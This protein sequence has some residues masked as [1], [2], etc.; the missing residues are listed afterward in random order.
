MPIAEIKIT[1]CQIETKFICSCCSCPT[2][3][4]VQW[5]ITG[6]AIAPSF[7]TW[8]E[9]K[10]LRSGWKGEIRAMLIRY[11][12]TYIRLLSQVIRRWL[13][14]LV[15]QTSV[16]VWAELMLH[17]VRIYTI[18]NKKSCIIDWNE[19]RLGSLS[20]ITTHI[21]WKTRYKIKPLNHAINGRRGM[22]KRITISVCL[23]QITESWVHISF[24]S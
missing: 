2:M 4:S 6:S 12:S 14:F 8:T 22:Q 19:I 13:R 1:N 23:L 21:L 18:I 9:T 3:L 24:F 17:F 5:T 16:F 20:K 7:F 15:K 11:Q 10:G